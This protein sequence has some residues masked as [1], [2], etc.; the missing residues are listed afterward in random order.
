MY[1][2]SISQLLVAPSKLFDYQCV[3]PTFVESLGISVSNEPEV[4]H[5]H[6]TV[7]VPKSGKQEFLY[8]GFLE[9]P[10]KFNQALQ[11][12]GSPS[13]TITPSDT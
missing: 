9:V 11:C 7:N 2:S 12:T 8:L 10:S 3:I 13:D 6:A 1:K 5:R 4:S